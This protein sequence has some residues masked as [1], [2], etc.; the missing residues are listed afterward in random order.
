MQIKGSVITG[1][2]L[3]AIHVIVDK[4]PQEDND[5]RVFARKIAKY[6]VLNGYLENAL[7]YNDYDRE[8][9]SIKKDVI[10]VALLYIDDKDQLSAIKFLFEKKE[11]APDSKDIKSI[12]IPKTFTNHEKYVLKEKL[13]KIIKSKNYE[14]LYDLYSKDALDDFDV[15]ED[16][17]KTIFFLNLAKSIKVLRD[18]FIV[19]YGKRNGIN[20]YFYFL[21]IEA[22]PSVAADEKLQLFFKI[23]IIDEPVNYEIY[24]IEL[25]FPNLEVFNKYTG[26]EMETESSVPK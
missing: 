3:F 19:Y 23:F 26:N 17:E 12:L 16:K 10:G 2:V 11:L 13:N 1:G 9:F 21:P 5:H 4:K 18:D 20:G 25:N 6:A 15:E 8:H 7:K 14:K 24:N 22:I